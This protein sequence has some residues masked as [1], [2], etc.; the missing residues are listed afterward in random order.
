MLKIEGGSQMLSIKY[1]PVAMAY[2]VL[3]FSAV[4]RIVPTRAEAEQVLAELT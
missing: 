1:S 4:V 3:W 2:Y